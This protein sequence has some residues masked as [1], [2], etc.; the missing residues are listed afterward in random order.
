M[1]ASDDYGAAIYS[2]SSSL[3]ISITACVLKSCTADKNGGAVS[4]SGGNSLKITDTFF[5]N[6]VTNSYEDEPGGGGI[7][8]A[9][10]SSSLFIYSSTFSSCK[11]NVQKIIRGGGGLFASRIQEC[12]SFSCRFISC[13]TYCAGGAA[14]FLKSNDAFLVSDSLFDGNHAN[15]HAGAVRG[16]DHSVSAYVHLQFCFFI[17]NSAPDNNGNDFAVAPEIS[18]CPFLHCFSTAASNRAAYAAGTT[19]FL[20]DDNWLPHDCNSFSHVSEKK[21]RVLH[22]HIIFLLST[23]LIPSLLLILS[24]SLWLLSPVL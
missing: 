23:I 21:Q 18:A 16:V 22:H 1:T 10:S 8:I 14:F 5:E 7:Y 17:D 19:A 11:A 15:V 9:G 13:S 20:Y 4:L 2:K 6:C 24:Y 3:T 12:Y